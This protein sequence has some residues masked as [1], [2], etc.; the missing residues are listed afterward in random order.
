MKLIMRHFFIFRIDT[1]LIFWEVL[2]MAK[3]KKGKAED[4]AE[5]TGK[6]IG[7]GAKK[8]VGIAKGFG[9]GMKSAVSKKK[10]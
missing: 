8:G 10:K 2:I 5:K 9:K 4:A 7:K 6:L 1:K 3:K